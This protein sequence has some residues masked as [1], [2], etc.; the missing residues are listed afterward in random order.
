MGGQN[1]KEFF[2]GCEHSGMPAAQSH[3]AQE[4]IE[5]ADESVGEV[6]D[7]LAAE[8]GKIV[9]P[10]RAFATILRIL[11][12]DTCVEC[13]SPRLPQ[14]SG[15]ADNARAVTHRQLDS[16]VACLAFQLLWTVSDTRAPHV[17]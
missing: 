8:T 3:F 12:R 4:H 14:I 7:K 15:Q 11:G 16:P 6:H 2:S 10:A 5:V 17:R 9:R 1:C 13:D